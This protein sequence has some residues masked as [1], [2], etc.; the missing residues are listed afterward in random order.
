MPE[1]NRV[2]T[3][4]AVPDVSSVCI[5]VA[6]PEVSRVPTLDAVPE[7]RMVPTLEVATFWTDACWR[8]WRLK[9][10]AISVS[11]TARGLA[12]EEAAG[13]RIIGHR[14]NVDLC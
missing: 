8:I 3:L 14:D 12:W 5:F 6:V 10:A 1:V 7:V 2:P 11:V 13:I 9:M 4:V